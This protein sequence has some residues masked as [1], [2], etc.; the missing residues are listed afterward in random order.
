M[1]LLPAAPRYGVSFL[2]SRLVFTDRNLICRLQ[3]KSL[4]DGQLCAMVEITLE[5]RPWQ[6]RFLWLLV[7]Q[8][9]VAI[10]TYRSL[11]AVHECVC[12]LASTRIG[13]EFIA[14]RR[15]P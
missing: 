15:E 4:I 8:I 7:H 5:K 10:P 14:A 6:R 2:G 3:G 9:A 1:P 11:S 13:Q 12:D